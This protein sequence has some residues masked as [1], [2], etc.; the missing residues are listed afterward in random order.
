MM[1]H[2]I[3]GLIKKILYKMSQCFPKPYEHFGGENNV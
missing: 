3:S 1:I 2:L